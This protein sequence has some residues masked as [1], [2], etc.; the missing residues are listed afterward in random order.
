MYSTFTYMYGFLTNEVGKYIYIC[1]YTIQKWMVWAVRPFATRFRP[2]QNR[3]F[4]LPS[5]LRD[6]QGDNVAF[7]L[8]WGPMGPT[9]RRLGLQ[10][11]LLYL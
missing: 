4:H 6:A 10:S 5:N 7:H 2:P 3:V 8:P 9:N 1:I 11:Q